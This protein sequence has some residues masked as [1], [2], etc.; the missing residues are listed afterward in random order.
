MPLSIATSIANTGTSRPGGGGNR[1]GN[2]K[3][4]NTYLLQFAPDACQIPKEVFKLLSMCFA[5]IHVLSSLRCRPVPVQKILKENNRQDLI[6]HAVRISKLFNAEPIP[7]LPHALIARLVHRWHEIR[8]AANEIPAIKSLPA[9]FEMLTHVFLLAENRPDLANAF[10]TH[11]THNISA[12]QT[13]RLCQLIEKCARTSRL[14]WAID[15]WDLPAS[16]LSY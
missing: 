1:G 11:K 10:A 13:Q 6:P 4:Y 2:V 5:S 9:G 3:A 14:S 16:S 8:D 7:I 15:A 12:T